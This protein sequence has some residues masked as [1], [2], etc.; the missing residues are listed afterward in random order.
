VKTSGAPPYE[1]IRAQ[2]AA[3]IGSGR[4]LPGARLPTVRALAADL[5]VAVNTAARAYKELETEGLVVT[6]RRAGTTVASGE[7]TAEVALAALAR[8]FATAARSAGLDERSA[9]DLV[10]VALRTPG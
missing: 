10:R 7:H 6:R 4:L 8:S 2:V 5:G 3:L 9:L 1:Q